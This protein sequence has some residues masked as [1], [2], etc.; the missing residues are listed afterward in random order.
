MAVGP[1]T[2]VRQS[3]FG[4]STILN[5]SPTHHGQGSQERRP[6]SDSARPP[7]R[8]LRRPPRLPSPL[9]GGAVPLL[10]VAVTARVTLLPS[11]RLPN[12]EPP[13]RE[14]GALGDIPWGGVVRAAVRR[15]DDDVGGHRATVSET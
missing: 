11:A 5:L 6:G 1:A 9:A 14:G 10:Y 13:R 2:G 12:Q 4:R 8:E 15:V 7:S 3:D